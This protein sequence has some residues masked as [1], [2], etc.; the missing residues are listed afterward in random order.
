MLN[1]TYDYFWSLS[2][3]GGCAYSYL[4]N[5]IILWFKY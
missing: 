2:V 3:P 1:V 5:K 4:E